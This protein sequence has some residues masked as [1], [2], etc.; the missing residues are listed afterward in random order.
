MPQ[1][2]SQ[3]SDPIAQAIVAASESKKRKREDGVDGTKKKV[4]FTAAAD[5][6]AT[7]RSLE[8]KS[9]KK[10]RAFPVPDEDRSTSAKSVPPKA[11][12][13]K[14]KREQLPTPEGSGSD[15]E[16]V[17]NQ[18]EASYLAKRGKTSAPKPWTSTKRGAQIDLESA[19]AREFDL[20]SVNDG[21]GP[22]E[23]DV[24]EALNSESESQDE[25]LQL[26]HET[27][28]RVKGV[29]VTHS[30]NSKV[31]YVPPNETK[32]ERDGR[33]VFVGNLPIEVI[34]SKVSAAAILTPPA[35]MKNL[36]CCH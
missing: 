25:P 13:S 26:K 33:T 2:A 9:R 24:P 12:K 3:T 32:E 5:D 35:K 15:V 1:Q 34:K 10:N 27:E 21:S 36:F 29:T 18:L 28:T 30:K 16:E 19:D 20:E 23:E 31:I 11:A 4:K 22:E 14:R 17:T 8:K 7:P 6:A